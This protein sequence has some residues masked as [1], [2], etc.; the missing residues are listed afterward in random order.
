MRVAMWYNNRDVR[1]EEMPVPKIGA[2]EILVRIEAS[3]LCGS[4]GME[5]YRL[6]K[7]PLVLGHEVAG[8][9][10][11][12]GGD[13]KTFQAGD[14]VSVAHH[15]PCNT[16]HYCQNG[17]HA[18]C[19][20]LQSTNFDPGG[21]CEYVRVPAINVDRG[22]FHLPDTV[23]YE[24]ATFVEPLACVVRGQKIAKLRPGNSVLVV[25]CGI[26]GQLHVM[27]ARSLGAG[28]IIAMDTIDFRLKMAQQFGADA[29]ISSDENVPEQV[30]ELNDGMLADQVIICRGKWIPQALSSIERGGTALFFAGAREDDK[31]PQTVNELFWRTEITLTSSYA[32]PPE[33]SIAA[34]NLIRSKRVPVNDMITH[35]LALADAVQG[36]Q[37]L[38]R[39]MEQDSMKIVIEPQK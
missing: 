26:S 21:F 10:V 14:R 24:D 15:V 33:D 2:H 20:T 29:V 27:T 16:C 6:H 28:R 9:V 3:G 18:A 35:R 39:P 22:V 8:E 38:T 30:R 12:V 32:G 37:L 25:G 5:W 31:I 4:D 36:F 17:H 1:V 23:S 19:K 7:A 11:E 34:I 13:V